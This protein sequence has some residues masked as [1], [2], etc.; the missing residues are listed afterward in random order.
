M[1][2]LFNLF[3]KSGDGLPSMLTR[4]ERNDPVIREF[5]N[6]REVALHFERA[7][8]EES[9]M[10]MAERIAKLEKRQPNLVQYD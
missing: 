5:Y 10:R 6:R 4:E 3:R 2:S 7:R 9:E 8:R 1:F